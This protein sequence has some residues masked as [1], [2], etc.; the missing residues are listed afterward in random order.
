MVA[1]NLN[2]RVFWQGVLILYLVPIL[3]IAWQ[4]DDLMVPVLV[5]VYGVLSLL[6]FARLMPKPERVEVP[7]AAVDRSQGQVQKLEV[8]IARREERI[9]ELEGSV[10][11]LTGEIRTLL[12]LEGEE[13]AAV[14]QMAPPDESWVEE[15]P[16]TCSQQVRTQYDAYI[17]LQRC[18]QKAQQLPGGFGDVAVDNA[19]EMRQLY[20]AFRDETAAI[21]MAYSRSEGRPLFANSVVQAFCGFEPEVFVRNFEGILRGG[22]ERWQTAIQGLGNGEEASVRLIV[23]ASNGQSVTLDC[24][25]GV[26]PSGPFKG[27]VVA[28]FYR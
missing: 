11:D 19:M 14:Q 28:V 17:L 10:R 8:E 16:D 15:L 26:I 1:D 5:S 18:I 3:L 12:Q 22:K 4:A 7:V 21:V 23:S 9:A 27:L 2:R 25:M 13:P 24:C 6:V 20:E